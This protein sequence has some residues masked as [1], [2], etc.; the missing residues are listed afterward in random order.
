MSLLFSNIDYEKIDFKS[1]DKKL[2]IPLIGADAAHAIRILNYITENRNIENSRSAVVMNQMYLIYV[3]PVQCFFFFGGG[4]GG[5]QIAVRCD[6]R[7]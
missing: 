2:I 5:G 3:P 4:G 7:R 6:R 1:F